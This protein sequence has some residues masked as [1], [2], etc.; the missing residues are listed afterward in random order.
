[1]NLKSFC[2]VSIGLLCLLSFGV[3]NAATVSYSITP[4]SLLFADPGYTPDGNVTAT[5]ADT[6]DCTDGTFTVNASPVAASGPGGSTPPLTAVTT[7]IGFPAGSNFSFNNAGYGQYQITT[8][9]TAC[10]T[11]T[12]PDPIVNIVTLREAKPIPSLSQLGLIIMA[13]MMGMGAVVMRRRQA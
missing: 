13:L 12:P 7:Y 2:T 4:P 5:V 6:L 3:A 1:M 9:T 10:A 8:T 11:G